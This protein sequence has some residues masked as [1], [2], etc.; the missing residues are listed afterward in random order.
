MV[1]HAIVHDDD[2][3]LLPLRGHDHSHSSTTLSKQQ[4]QKQQ[5][6]QDDLVRTAKLS[7]STVHDSVSLSLSGPNDAGVDLHKGHHEAVLKDLPISGGY[8]HE[9]RLS[10]SDDRFD[11]DNDDDDDDDP[12]ALL[13]AKKESNRDKRRLKIAI[14]LCGAFFV[15]ELLGGLWSESLALLS[16][17]FHLLTDI[18]SFIISLAAIYLSQR[19]STATHTFGYHRAEVLGALFSIFLIWG[20]TLLLVVEAYDRVRHPIDI[21]G[22][23]MSVVAGLGVFVNIILM[24][25]LGGHHHHHGDEHD[26]EHGHG[27]GHGHSHSHT[28]HAEHAPLQSEDDHDH[29]THLSLDKPASDH[30]QQ[31]DHSGHGHHHHHHHHVNLNIT[32]ATLHVLGD[33]LSSVGVLI[34]SLVITFFPSLVYLDPICTFVFSILVI[35]TTVGIFKRSVSILMES[36]PRNMDLEEIKDAICDVPGVL[37]VKTLHVWSLTVGQSALAGTVYLQPEVKDVRRATA[38]VATARRM[39]KKRYGIKEF[40]LQ[41]AVYSPHGQSSSKEERLKLSSSSSSVAIATE[42]THNHHHDGPRQNTRNANS[43]SG[44]GGGHSHGSLD[45]L[46]RHDQ[47]II[48]S[49]GDEDLDEVKS[50]HKLGSQVHHLHQHHHHHSHNQYHNQ[51]HHTMTQEITRAGTPLSLYRE[52]RSTAED[53]DESESEMEMELEQQVPLNAESKRWA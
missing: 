15:V 33:L 50:P 19:S 3:P 22:K 49:I 40:T 17:S 39:I 35:A 20:L 11:C 34:S 51:Q 24:F 10:Q 4:Q 6:Q 48:F 37:E 28:T 23:T 7:G 43:S 29:D 47:D 44:G 14:G 32:A 52:N 25:V 16:D 30:H 13:E 42:G 26:H 9:G 1:S 21:D 27:H 53:E 46:A 41:V 36:V 8:G 12:V 18:T 45:T 5:R 31:H 38:I 2:E